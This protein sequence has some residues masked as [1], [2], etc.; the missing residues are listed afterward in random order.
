MIPTLT[1]AYYMFIIHQ[2]VCASV[3][4]EHQ[5]NHWFVCSCSIP[6]G[7]R[8]LGIFTYLYLKV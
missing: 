2:V 8:F 7:S 4:R 6:I 3:V 1:C 5:L